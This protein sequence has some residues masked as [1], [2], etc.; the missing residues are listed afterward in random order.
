MKRF[1]S[2]LGN[3]DR[4]KKISILI[5]CDLALVCLSINFTF[6]I[7]FRNFDFY[8]IDDFDSI[9]FINL[10]T[11]VFLF[12][13]F[14]LYRII[15]RYMSVNSMLKLIFCL[16]LYVCFYTI[17]LLILWRD[18][19]VLAFEIFWPNPIIL[20][21]VLFFL[22]GGIRQL[23]RLIYRDMY[24]IDDSVKYNIVVYGTDKSALS[25]LSSNQNQSNFKIVG[26]LTN[27]IK[28]KNTYINN[29]KV[30][31]DY[32]HIHK[33]KNKFKN[34][35]VLF[36]SNQFE[37]SRK[38]FLIN[39]FL[40]ND[41]TVKNFLP[42][43]E[44]LEGKILDKFFEI[45]IEDL[46]GRSK[47]E[48]NTAIIKDKISKKTIFI[49]G[50]GGSIGSELTTQIISLMPKK[51]IILDNSEFNLF[52]IEKKI[53]SI[54]NIKKLET[55]LISILGSVTDLV[56]I[57]NI[58]SKNTID[59]VYHAAAYKHVP[60][61]EHNIIQGVF[62]NVLGT[63]NVATTAYNK[64]V[65]NFVFISTDKAV[66]PTNM[67]G[68]TKRLGELVVQGIAK[69]SIKNNKPCL[70]SIVRFG[71]VLGSSGS[72]VP[73][74]KEQIRS[75]G[76]V[77][78]THQDVKRYFMTIQE[79][80][81]LVIQTTSMPFNGQVYLLDMGEQIKIKDLAVKMIKLSGYKVFDN[82]KENND[83]NSIKIDF[84]GLRDG[85]KLYEE[86]IIGDNITPTSHPKIKKVEEECYLWSEIEA[87]IIEIENL[88]KKFDDKKI[89]EKM[90]IYVKE[91]KENN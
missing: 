31:G 8:H 41:I 66:R 90:K 1:I 67:M 78:V 14:N 74:F 75:G 22:I 32:D 11:A 44:F 72:V 15:T 91:Y 25:F 21:L 56:L 7:T 35:I 37:T 6:L 36:I 34:I 9:L 63:Y 83:K 13:Q 5:L 24:R 52:T 85:E 60:L 48:T 79:A 30:L 68:A 87:I 4:T 77:T 69:E 33:L 82:N 89:K 76:P 47:I 81:E 59:Q 54:I 12:W 49:T 28:L 88:I 43:N 23:I 53:Q 73:I 18:N 46:L 71:N 2:F 26:I 61:V 50:A 19:K 65:S 3:L 58:M 39:Y 38:N 45:S 64:N 57:E 62:N 10:F 70:F 51:L 16:S 86:L 29:I 80:V 27:D 84:T 40:D 42:I 20:C 17:S 55:E